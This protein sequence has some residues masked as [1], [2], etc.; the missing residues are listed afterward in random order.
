MNWEQVRDLYLSACG[1]VE[2]AVNER[3]LHIN[4]AYRNLCGSLELPELHQSNAVVTTVAGQ[5]WVDMDCDVFAL[6]WIV[7]KATAR[8]LDPEPSGHR[9]RSRFFEAGQSRPPEGSV[10][11]YVRKGNRIWLRDTPNAALD[12]V[13]SFRFHPDEVTDADLAEHPVTPAQYDIPLVQLAVG[14]YFQFHP[15]PP[16]GP[17]E[18]PDIGRGDRFIAQAQ[19]QIAS[20]KHPVAEEQ[21]D[22]RD[23][24]RQAGY[25]FNVR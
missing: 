8:K 5:D 11:F 22:R 9:G 25:S 19:A 1:G 10:N 12:L 14:S 6:D 4:S 24:L 20:L 23:Y 21:K 7:N 17:G 15:P 13:V 3:W 16:A 2:L 18:M